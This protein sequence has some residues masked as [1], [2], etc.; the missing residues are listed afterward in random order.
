LLGLEG[1]LIHSPLRDRHIG[2]CFRAV[3]FISD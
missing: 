3:D 2:R 1:F